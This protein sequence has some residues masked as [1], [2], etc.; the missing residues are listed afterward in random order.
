MPVITF[1]SDLFNKSKGAY[2]AKIGLHTQKFCQRAAE[3][4]QNEK[5]RR[6]LLVTSAAADEMLSRLTGLA[7]DPSASRAGPERRGSLS[8]PAVLS[9]LKGYISALLIISGTRQATLLGA[10]ELS[11]NEFILIWRRVFSYGAE[12]ISVFNQLLKVFQNGGLDELARA[13]G[14]HM[15][16]VL[17]IESET[18]DMP[19][20]EWIRTMLMDDFAAL[21]RIAGGSAIT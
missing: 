14:R 2:Y 15:V 16:D 1:L 3:L 10:M 21:V 9:A 18:T 17:K 20:Y 7:R 11:E 8:K 19:E 5:Q 13:T 4:A 6:F 12:D